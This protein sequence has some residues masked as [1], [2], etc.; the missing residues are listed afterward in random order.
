MS[1]S[2]TEAGDNGSSSATSARPC[3]VMRE[4]PDFL[5]SAITS[6]NLTCIPQPPIPPP[7]VVADGAASVDDDGASTTCCN[8]RYRPSRNCQRGRP[9]G[10]Q[11]SH[12]LPSSLHSS[13]SAH[14]APPH[15]TRI[16]SHVQ[17]FS[18]NVSAY[19]HTVASSLYPNSNHNVLPN[20]THTP[21]KPPTSLEMYERKLSRARWAARTVSSFYN[22]STF[23]ALCSLTWAT[24]VLL[25]AFVDDLQF[26]DYVMVTS[27]LL[28]EAIRLASAAFFTILLTHGLARSSQDPQN[29]IHG[30]DD[31]YRRALVA[32]ILSSLLQ[33]V[34]ILPSFVC[35]II[36]F[37]NLDYD[38]HNIYSSLLIFYLLIICNA[39]VSSITLFC[40][41]ISFFSLRDR[42]DQSTLRY[43]DELLQR[44][45]CF[46][47]I[48]A[49]DFGFFQFAYRML[50]SE[51]VRIVQPEA[52]VK[53][54]RKLI[55]YLYNHRLG[56]DFL[57]IVLE[58]DDAFVQQAAVNMAGFWADPSKKVG[59][60]EVKLAKKVLRGMADKVGSGQVGW[61][62]VNSFGGIA[63]RDPRVLA[64]TRTSGGV[65]LLERLAEH[66]DGKSS[67]SLV[68]VRTLVLYY[69][70]SLEKGEEVAVLRTE[71]ELEGK[72]RQLL[73]GG[74][75][76]ER[77]RLFAGYL[78]HLLGRLDE[79]CYDDVAS[80]RPSKDRYWF[81]M[82]LQ[83][84]HFIRRQCQIHESPP[85]L[86]ALPKDFIRK[87]D[88]VGPNGQ[89]FL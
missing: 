77:A 23:L 17:S 57:L 86:L 19:L 76:V 82:E 80:I 50:G 83:L 7:P 22:L 65:P 44:G 52:V 13:A 30:K 72:L 68:Y 8:W 37:R 39:T 62:A 55:E 26:V 73:A 54:H 89:R 85:D 66:V 24:V 74:E 36:R 31:H 67:G 29:I 10:Q 64:E 21:N 3:E 9:P 75:R 45:I 63:R 58:D 56:Q 84:F 27:L 49:D 42:Y 5:D 18:T 43:Y 32:R 20:P 12:P 78:L 11:R 4:P 34:L 35:P 79:A 41:S 81:R 33:T 38:N 88:N 51:F 6:Y 53:N 40:S 46:G 28:L 60:K 69:H 14:G 16:Y 2:G 61:A 15:D 71:R 1:G 70:Y 59:L 47:V 48:Q 87:D 25:G